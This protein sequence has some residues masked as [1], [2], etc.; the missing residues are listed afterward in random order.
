[1]MHRRSARK[2]LREIQETIAAEADFLALGD[3]FN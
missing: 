1:M 3:R 2:K